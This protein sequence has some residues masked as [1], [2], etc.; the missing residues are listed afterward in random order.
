MFLFPVL[1]CLKE[2]FHECLDLCKSLDAYNLSNKSKN[3]KRDL[4]SINADRIIYK[5]AI[6]M[7]Q[8][9]ALEELFG[10]PDEVRFQQKVYHDNECHIF[11]SV[12]VG[13]K[14]RRFCC[15]V[16]HNRYLIHQ[17][18]NCSTCTKMQLKSDCLC[19]KDKDT[20]MPLT[21][22]KMNE[23][24]HHLYQWKLSPPSVP[25]SHRP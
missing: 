22:H 4:D 15:T 9:A 11:F 24:D 18:V 5:Y 7:C 20:F 1:K 3:E 8:S 23:M 10:Q 21:I 12:S 6:E 17:I 16:C 19:Y 2:R 13:T 14:R 25:L